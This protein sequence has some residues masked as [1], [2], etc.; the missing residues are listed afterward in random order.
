MSLNEAINITLANSDVV[1]V[2]GGV[3]AVNSGSTIYDAAITNTTIDEE[4]AAFDPTITANSNWRQN[5]TPAAQIDPT[6]PVG[7]SIGG[8][9]DERYD[10]DIGLSR[11]NQLGG[12]SSLNVASNSSFTN[13]GLFA[14]NPSDRTTTE[15]SYVQPLL[16]GAGRQ[17]N[18][19]PIVLAR[20]QTEQSFFNYKSAV[21]SSVQGV[22]AAYWALV[23][24]KTDLWARQ[25]QVEQAEFA[26]ERARTAAEVGQINV[27]ELAQTELAL[28]RFRASLLLSQGAVLQQQAALLSILGLPPYESQRTVPVTPPFTERIQVDWDTLNTVAQ[29][30]RP[31]I[32]Q[33]KLVLEADQQQLLLSDNAARPELNG[34]AR[35]RWNGLE[36]E[37]PTG[38]TLRSQSGDFEDWTLGVTFSVP[39]GLRQG[40]ANLRGSQLRIQRDR[41]NLAQG[42]QLMQHDLA[43]SIRNLDQF[44]SQ[45]ERFQAV[46][47]AARTNL[48]LQLE[49]FNRGITQFIVVL[50]AIVDWGDAVSAEARSLTDYNTELARLELQSG[51]IL[52]THDIVF[53]EERFQSIGPLGRCADPHCYPR[54][55]PPTPSVARYDGGDEPSENLFGLEDPTAQRTENDDSDGEE[56]M[57]EIDRELEFDE[58]ELSDPDVDNDGEIS[59]EEIDKI[60]PPVR[61]G[62]RS[63]RFFSRVFTR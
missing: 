42:L 55:Q 44:Y 17:V 33:L 7:V 5:E 59:D 34:V 16:R 32:I 29:A 61:T 10:F 35:Y 26:N 50:Q 30:Q 48:E 39:I 51:T 47:R 49:Q 53:F 36:G 57:L 43:I 19:A 25:Q 6:S 20:L 2:L 41:A 40:R 54:S 3:R 27:G 56:G 60:L 12:R 52:Q 14:L 4:K 63:G 24:A 18:R 37:V 9:Q 15:L 58:L 45:Y 8:L 23:F 22:V 11:Q 1:R 21:Q 13:P 38:Q 46:R 31:D 62:R 28:E